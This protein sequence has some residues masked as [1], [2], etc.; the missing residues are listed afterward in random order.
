MLQ[1][2]QVLLTLALGLGLALGFGNPSLLCF[3]TFALLLLLGNALLLRL[4]LRI[5]DRRR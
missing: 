2:R 3:L 1:R 5:S 4:G